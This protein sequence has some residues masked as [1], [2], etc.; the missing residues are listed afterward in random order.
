MFYNTSRSTER[1]YVSPDCTVFDI[2]CANAL[3]QASSFH[4]Q[5]ESYGSETDDNLNWF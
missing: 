5:T 2:N 1:R 4:F 3:M